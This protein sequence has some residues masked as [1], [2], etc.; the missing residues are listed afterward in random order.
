MQSITRE[1]TFWEKK[2]YRLPRKLVFNHLFWDRSN[3]ARNIFLLMGIRCSGIKNRHI[4]F[5]GYREISKTIRI[6]K[7]QVNNR[8]WELVEHDLPLVVPYRE[9][10]G[11]RPY[12]YKLHSNAI[13]SW[14]REAYFPF[15][16]K[17]LENEVWSRL[18]SIAQDLYLIIGGVSFQLPTDNMYSSLD[19]PC[20]K[21]ANKND[22]ESV[23]DIYETVYN[24]SKNKYECLDIESALCELEKSKLIKDDE[25]VIKIPLLDSNQISW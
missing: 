18:S 13:A 1:N 23:I 15:Y 2:Y 19:K 17:L 20:V 9:Q 4:C 22:I 21:I 24:K 12:S 14:D 7:N 3:A 8:I 10:N 5:V 11:S 6:P 16:G 25:D